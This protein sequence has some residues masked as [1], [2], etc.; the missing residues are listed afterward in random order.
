MLFFFSSRRRHTRSDRDWSSDVCSSDLA[1]R[2]NGTGFPAS[3][4]EL[5]AVEN[6]PSA[7][8]F[9]SRSLPGT[10]TPAVVGSTTTMSFAVAAG[11]TL[12]NEITSSEL[13]CAATISETLLEVVAS[14]L[15]ICTAT[16]PTETTSA[17][18]TGAVHSVTE[19]QVV[20][21]AAPPI[22][23]TDPGPGLDATKL[24]P[25][26]RRVNPLAAPAYTLAG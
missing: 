18:V 25:S 21:R 3:E 15:R 20:V 12:D 6:S 10:E 7:A 24:L 8:T 19:A 9:K 1:G 17:G 23:K 26:T 4:H 16:L 22:S 11:A 13:F 14:G 2:S 5:F